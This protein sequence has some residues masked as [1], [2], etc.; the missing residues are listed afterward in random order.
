MK[1]I[2][3]SDNSDTAGRGY[4]FTTPTAFHKSILHGASSDELD[5]TKQSKGLLKG[6]ALCIKAK[7]SSGKE[8]FVVNIYQFTAGAGEKQKLLWDVLFGWVKRCGGSKIVLIKDFNCTLLDPDTG[9]VCRCRNECK[10]ASKGLRGFCRR[11][12]KHNEKKNG[13]NCCGYT[14]PLMKSIQRAHE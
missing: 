9:R 13:C 10:R 6:Q 7:L 14:L 8:I 12:N 5:F 4:L 1:D 2:T 3:R 11:T